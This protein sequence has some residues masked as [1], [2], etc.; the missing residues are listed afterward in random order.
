FQGIS[1]MFG[2]VA[3]L[4]GFGLLIAMQGAIR[5]PPMALLL[6]YAFTFVEGIGIAPII[7]TYLRV[8]GSGV[9]VDAAT[10]T[11]LGMAILGGIAYTFGVD[12]R[13][14]SGIATGA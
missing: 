7:A 12:W 6:F 9:V 11:G 8:D 14:F 10:A 2:F 4:V 1:P 3:M 5:N 13:R